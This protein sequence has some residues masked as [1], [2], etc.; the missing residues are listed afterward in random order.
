V[1][2]YRGAIPKEVQ[3]RYWRQKKYNLSEEEYDALVIR[4]Q[5]RCPICQEAASLVVDH[6]HATDL[7]RGLLCEAC[8]FGLGFFK[9][10]PNNLRRAIEYL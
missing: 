2:E 8:N 9:D 7:V 5:G 3:R 4:Y 6:D 10:D 1:K